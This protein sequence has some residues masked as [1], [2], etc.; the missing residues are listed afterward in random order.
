M[1]C[2]AYHSPR[3]V[4]LNTAICV[5]LY[6]TAAPP[7]GGKSQTL[8]TNTQDDKATGRQG[9][10]VT[11]PSGARG[12]IVSTGTLSPCLLVTVSS[13]E[14]SV[15]SLTGMND[16]VQS[17]GRRCSRCWT[18]STVGSVSPVLT[19]CLKS[20]RF[21]GSLTTSFHSHL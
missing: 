19:N 17:A 6:L 13:S 5:L 9:G 3:L 4:K 7:S 21:S 2:V 11:A 14:R 10:K 16:V 1:F 20:R 8:P 12:T 15:N 18:N